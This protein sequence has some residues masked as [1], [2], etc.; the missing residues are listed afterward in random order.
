VNLVERGLELL[1]DR[2][3]TDP[4]RLRESLSRLTQVPFQR[5]VFAHGEPILKDASQHLRALLG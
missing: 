4:R 1:P 5:A 3:C 2:Y